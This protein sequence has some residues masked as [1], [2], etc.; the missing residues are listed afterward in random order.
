M[1]TSGWMSVS[2]LLAAREMSVVDEEGVTVATETVLGYLEKEKK[3]AAIRFLVV[4]GEDTR[5][6]LMLQGLPASAEVLMWK[7]A[8]RG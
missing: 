8:L 5:M 2:T 7:P 6:Q 4:I 3:A 1:V